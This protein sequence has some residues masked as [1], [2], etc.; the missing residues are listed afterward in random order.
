MC[1][2]YTNDTCQQLVT[3]AAAAGK[4]G[5]YPYLTWIGIILIAVGIF[6]SMRKP[7]WQRSRPEPAHIAGPGRRKLAGPCHVTEFA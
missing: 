6:M 7:A 5:Y 3:A 1:L 2:L 4:M